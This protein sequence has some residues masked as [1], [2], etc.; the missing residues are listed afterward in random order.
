MMRRGA[1][2]C[3]AS[4]L[5][6]LMKVRVLLPSQC[7]LLHC[8][9]WAALAVTCWGPRQTGQQT[10]GGVGDAPHRPTPARWAPPLV[11]P[12]GNPPWIEPPFF[13]DFGQVDG[14]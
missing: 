12:A 1:S 7:C 9:C 8:V 6:A 2:R 3:C 10:G 13:C 11:L 5:A 4:C 14:R